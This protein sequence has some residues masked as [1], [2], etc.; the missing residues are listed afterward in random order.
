MSGQLPAIIVVTPLIFSFVVPV[1]GHWRRRRCLPLVIVALSISFLSSL[2]LL[3]VVIAE[4]SIHYRLGGWAPPWGIEYVLD[5]L[6][7]FI[8]TVVSLV[9][10]LV[11]FYSKRSLEEEVPEGRIP[12]LYA[13]FLLNVTGLLGMTVTGDMFNLYVLMEIASFSA[14]AMV[15]MGDKRSLVAS[16]RYV[17]LGTVGACL[18]LLG[19]GYLYIA[20]GSLNMADLSRLLPPLY[21]SKVVLSAF[22][23]IAS[24]VGIK[25]ALFP[26]HAWLPD[27]YTY[28]P[29]AVSALIAPT[30]TKVGCYILIRVTFFV[31]KPSF[32]L[33]IFPFTEIL[34]WFAVVAM[35][36]GSLYAIAQKDLRRML[37]YSTV[38]QIGYIAMGIALANR[39]GISGALLH[40]LNEAL[41][42]GCLFMVAGAIFYRLR[43]RN[44]F[45][46]RYAFE[47]IP[48]TMIAFV[49]AAFSMIGVPPTCGFFSKLYL[50]L[51]ALEA[52]KGIF[53]GALLISAVLNIVYF[54]NVIKYAF[55]GVRAPAYS[56]DGGEPVREGPEEV[57][58]S[59]AIPIWIAALGILAA[60][61]LSGKI[62]T[63]IIELAI[64]KALLGG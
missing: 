23:L 51:G 16:F 20:T 4:G 37:A 9:A 22:I 52:K 15:G 28:A 50:L 60:G 59:M 39:M 6:N 29:S 47:K 55:F 13:L 1:V 40:I 62:I 11:A 56:Y 3:R 10:L 7:T 27:A 49:V 18:Y 36:A 42:K 57:P 8:A 61:L 34:G 35:I 58:L 41:T 32:S 31:F 44:V 21:R 12:Q 19:V 30:T 54:F 38:A 2:Y 53:I 17:V 24:G 48:F 63:G 64:P 5:S 43:L 25:M 14:Y 33:R 46:L 26:L 45:E